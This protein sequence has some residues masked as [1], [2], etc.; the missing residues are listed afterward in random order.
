MKR[1]V[2]LLTVLTSVAALTAAA[3]TEN[4]DPVGTY[5]FTTY[6][7]NQ[8]V[9]G[10]IKISKN[11][12]GKLVAVLDAPSAGIPV[13]TSSSVEVEGKDVTL[14]IPYGQEGDIW[15]EVTLDGEEVTGR[16]T[17][18]M[19]SGDITGKRVTKSGGR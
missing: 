1:V 7:N 3:Q 5:E 15:I 2:G 12:E 9:T 16:W 13:L 6:A 11:T 8:W 19:D 18:G 10:T 14:R 4:V 17:L